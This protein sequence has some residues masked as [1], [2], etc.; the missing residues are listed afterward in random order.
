ML[1]AQICPVRERCHHNSKF[2]EK[3]CLHSN[4]DI[5]AKPHLSA[6]SPR[7]ASL[8]IDKTSFDDRRLSLSYLKVVLL[9][10]FL[11]LVASH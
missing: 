7:F 2:G 1:C 11:W 8:L 3:I 9:H 10:F 5:R 6:I 4:R